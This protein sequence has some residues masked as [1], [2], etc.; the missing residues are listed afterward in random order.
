[1]TAHQL[2]QLEL[3][4]LD[5][6]K[7][8]YENPGIT[9]DNSLWDIL[10]LPYEKLPFRALQQL[11]LSAV[12]FNSAEREIAS[13]FDFRSLRSLKLRFCPGWEGFLCHIRSL[14]QPIFLQ[15]L[16]IQSNVE[17]DNADNAAST[18]SAFLEAIEGLQ[19]LFIS[20]SS[21]SETLPIWRSMLRHRSTLR[22]FVHHQ[23]SIDFRNEE[24]CDLPDLSLIVPDDLAP[25]EDPLQH[26]FNNLDLEC[27]GLCCRPQYLVYLAIWISPDEWHPMLTHPH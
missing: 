23:R 8:C 25:L 6:R 15:T 20:T 16:D 22:R 13:A 21:P 9:E 3:D 10:D 18:I 5:W 24:P 1:M 27:V 26:P 17:Y 12:S 7:V 19:H 14:Q 11:S 4:L 2:V